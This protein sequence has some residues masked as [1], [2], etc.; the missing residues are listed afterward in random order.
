MKI[1]CNKNRITYLLSLFK[2]TEEE[3][4]CAINKD[5]KN[6]I[7]WQDIYSNEIELNHLK[8]IDKVFNKGLFYYS[9][10]TTPKKDAS[11]SIFFRKDSFTSD[12]NLGARQRVR[13]FEEKIGR[14]SCRERV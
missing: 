1:E 8:R 3:L 13:E 14:A 4:L 11:I 2:M 7:T 5:L 10:P 9:D 12:L 6:K